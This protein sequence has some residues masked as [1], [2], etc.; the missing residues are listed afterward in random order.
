MKKIVPRLF[1]NRLRHQMAL[2][3]CPTIDYI[4]E[5]QGIKRSV[6]TYADTKLITPYNTYLFH[7][8]H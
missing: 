5:P 1:L 2:Q 6:L 7:V 4:L 8:C 3:S